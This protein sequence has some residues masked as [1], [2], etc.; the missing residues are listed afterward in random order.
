MPLTTA[1]IPAMAERIEVWPVERLIFYSDN[2]R[3]HSDEPINKIAVSMVEFGFT[4]PVL[5]RWPGRHR[6]WPLA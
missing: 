5:S 2:A 1:A 6:P 3:T 4:N